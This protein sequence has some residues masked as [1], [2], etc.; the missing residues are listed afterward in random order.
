MVFCKRSSLGYVLAAAIAPA[1]ILQTTLPAEAA[2]FSQIVSFGDSLVDTGNAFGLTGIPPA[3]YFEGHFSNGPVVPEY[4][5]SDLGIA[6]TSLGFGG[7]FSNEFG[8]LLF[9]GN[10]ISPVP[11]TLLQV[12]AFA[13]NPLRVDPNALYVIWAGSNDYLFGQQRDPF[14]VAGNI[15]SA[16]AALSNAGARNFLLPNLP[17]LG[18]LPL[19]GLRGASPEQVAGLNALS[20][21][22]NQIL[23]KIAADLGATDDITVNVLDINSLF[24]SAIAGDLGFGNT[25]DACTRSPLC[26]SNPAVQDTYLFWDEVHPTTRAY[27]LVADNALSLIDPE[28]AAVPE[29]AVAIGLIFVGGLSLNQLKRKLPTS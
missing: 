1:A 26:V 25:T 22:H 18:N 6:E 11:G 8:F 14:V 13:A 16:V 20:A 15:G 24:R 4:L 28:P 9:G 21:G 3:P 7:A 5:A 12:N 17:D 27:R 2:R 19:L 29:P 10:P 23:L